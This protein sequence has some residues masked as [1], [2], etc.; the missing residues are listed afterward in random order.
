MFK[1]TCKPRGSH[2]QE[3]HYFCT[4]KKNLYL[5]AYCYLVKTSGENK[6]IPCKV[7]TAM[8]SYEIQ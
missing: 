8:S 3:L 2:F 6:D 5:I 4:V 1:V 7:M